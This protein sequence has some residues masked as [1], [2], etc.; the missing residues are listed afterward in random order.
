MIDQKHLQA[1]Q[2]IME[3]LQGQMEMGPEDF[4]ERLGRQP[5]MKAPMEEEMPM[6][7]MMGDEMP[8]E[9]EG[10]EEMLKKRIMGL[11]SR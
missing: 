6:E 7:E 11:R 10:P 9:E 5:Q 4:D 3:E 8:M 1:L 2:E